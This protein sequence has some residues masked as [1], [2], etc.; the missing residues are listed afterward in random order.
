MQIQIEITGL[1]ATIAKLDTIGTALKVGLAPAM[2]E[3]GIMGSR[4]FSGIAFQSKGSTFDN[5]WPALAASTVKDKEAHWRGLPDMVRT[6]RLRNSFS[7]KLEPNAVRLLNTAP[8]F[9]YHQSSAQPRK[10]LPRRQMIGVDA[11]LM[12]IVEIA[13]KKQVDV[14]IAGVR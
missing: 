10:R 12:S 14:I 2:T 8:Y 6:G 9:A 4:Y 7:Y 1:D 3:I 5:P 11:A 13:I